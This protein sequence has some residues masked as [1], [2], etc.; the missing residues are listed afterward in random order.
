MFF[1]AKREPYSKRVPVE[2][3]SANP[4]AFDV[5]KADS[6]LNLGSSS[7]A[8]IVAI[9]T[10]LTGSGRYGLAIKWFGIFF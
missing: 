10:A 3:S 6:F 9:P 4:S 2:L 7:S 1:R 8:A 5:S